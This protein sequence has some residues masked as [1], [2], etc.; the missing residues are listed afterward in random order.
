MKNAVFWDVTPCGSSHI[1]CFGRTYRLHHQGG[2]SEIGTVLSVISISTLIM[3]AI[4]FSKTSVHTSATRRHIPEDGIIL[5]GM[6]VQAFTAACEVKWRRRRSSG[7][8][9]SHLQ[10][11]VPTFV[12]RGVS[13]GQC[14]G[15]LT[16]VNHSFLDRSRYFSFK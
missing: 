13:R 9:W 7:E 15:S 4:C 8:N 14:G 5:R 3:E 6:C 1:L 10:N 2:N 16:V 12:D 11:L